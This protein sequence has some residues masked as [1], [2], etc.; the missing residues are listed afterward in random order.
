MKISWDGTTREVRIRATLGHAIEPDIVLD[1]IEDIEAVVSAAET[2]DGNNKTLSLADVT[3][4]IEELAA[5]QKE[6][7]KEAREAQE[8]LEKV[9]EKLE[10]AH[11][12]LEDYR[13]E[14]AALRGAS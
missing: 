7:E 6:A 9:E 2:A 10:K 14:I 5:S 11:V 4:V 13:I 3:D 1:M 8:E 12:D